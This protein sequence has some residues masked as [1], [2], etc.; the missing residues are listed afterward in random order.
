MTS[1]DVSVAK[2]VALSILLW[3]DATPGCQFPP[4]KELVAIELTRLLGD[5]SIL[6]AV[7]GLPAAMETGGVARM[8]ALNPWDVDSRDLLATFKKAVPDHMLTQVQLLIEDRGHK[9]VV[10][11]MIQYRQRTPTNSKERIASIA[12]AVCAELGVRTS[13]ESDVAEAYAT[14]YRDIVRV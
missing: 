7:P 5:P 3:R 8:V 10:L 11:D 6:R 4:M 14:V 12:K 13:Q 1:F 9:D 2:C